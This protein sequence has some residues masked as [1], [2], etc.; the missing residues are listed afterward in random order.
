MSDLLAVARVS[1]TPV[2]KPKRSAATGPCGCAR[3]TCWHH[4]NCRNGG[5]V[6][7]TRDVK[8]NATFAPSVILCR[9]CAAPTQRTYVA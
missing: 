1:E 9:E 7:I 2:V 8:A 6:R 5:V 3:H 4:R